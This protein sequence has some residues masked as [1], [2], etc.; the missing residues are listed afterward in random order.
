MN[1]EI[2]DDAD[3]MGAVDAQ[4]GITTAE[5]HRL[6][7]AM[8]RVTIYNRM[9][10]HV[11]NKLVRSEIDKGYHAHWYAIAWKPSPK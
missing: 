10:R 4:P 2:P 1:T 7:P 8:S 9:R 11:R 3:I 6:F 5:I